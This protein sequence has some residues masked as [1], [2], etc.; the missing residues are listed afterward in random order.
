MGTPTI[1]PAFIG[2]AKPNRPV[3]LEEARLARQK[4]RMPEFK[5]RDHA[6]G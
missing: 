5:G 4:Q 3:E 1:R 6:A 2:A